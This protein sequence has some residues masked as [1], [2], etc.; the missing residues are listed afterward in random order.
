[1][2]FF[3]I[4]NNN[5]NNNNDNNKTHT[6]LFSCEDALSCDMAYFAAAEKIGAEPGYQHEWFDLTNLCH[7]DSST[8]TLWTGPFP[9]EGLSH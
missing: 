1:M 8:T 6:Q 3:F 7:E 4:N 5:N 2:L 9:I